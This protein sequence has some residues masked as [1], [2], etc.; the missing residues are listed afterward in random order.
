MT[1]NSPVTDDINAIKNADLMSFIH[2]DGFPN[3]RY[4][5]FVVHE[6][7]SVPVQIRATQDAGTDSSGNVT[8]NIFP[9]L[10][11]VPGQNQNLNNSLAAGMKV[12]VVPSHRAGAI[13]SGNPL[14][15]AM[16]KMLNTDPFSS[17]VTTDPDSGAS[18][19]NYWGYVFDKAERRFVTDQIWGSTLVAENSM[20]LLFPLT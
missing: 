5:T 15:L 11:S 2:V 6:P 16:P 18:I 20:R 17:V 19:R 9:A 12:K 10:S 4:L 1:F 7:S 14:Y 3:M 8:F 13:M